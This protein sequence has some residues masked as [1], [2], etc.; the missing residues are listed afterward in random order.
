MSDLPVDMGLDDTNIRILTIDPL[1][2]KFCNALIWG[3]VG[4][5]GI[6]FVV[7]YT[8]SWAKS[9]TSTLID[10]I[11]HGYKEISYCSSAID[12]HDK[13][14]RGI[15]TII[16]EGNISGNVVVQTDSDGIMTKA[17]LIDLLTGKT[18]SANCNIAVIVG[19][20][21]AN[22]KISSPMLHYIFTKGFL[23]SFNKLVQL[24]GRLKRGNGERVKQ[25]RIHLML[26]LPYFSTMYYSILSETDDRE[27]GHQLREILILTRVSMC[28]NECSRQ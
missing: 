21:A 6:D 22:C 16:R 11:G 9:A 13:I 12:A 5:A 25:D 18:T 4:R 1:P 23:R 24:M 10:Y 14:K 3:Q 8:C 17:W 2:S 26:S 20:S 27:R 28:L 7:E 15:Q 19:T